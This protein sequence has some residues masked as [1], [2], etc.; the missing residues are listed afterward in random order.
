MIKDHYKTTQWLGPGK[1]H[2]A[3]AIRLSFD[4]IEGLVHLLF[5]TIQTNFGGDVRRQKT[6]TLTYPDKQPHDNDNNPNKR[7]H[8]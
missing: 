8:N 2:V 6:Q 7:D 3:Q 5:W 4:N 1:Q